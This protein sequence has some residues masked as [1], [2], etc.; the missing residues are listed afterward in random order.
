MEK[1]QEFLLEVFCCKV[2]K[3]QNEAI[4]GVTLGR[5]D[6][7]SAFDNKPKEK[8]AEKSK[9]QQIHLKDRVAKRTIVLISREKI[10]E[11][12][13]ERLSKEDQMVY[14]TPKFGMGV[15]SGGFENV[16]GPFYS[17]GFGSSPENLQKMHSKSADAIR[18]PVFPRPKENKK[19]PMVLTRSR[20]SLDHIHPAT[21]SRFLY[22]QHEKRERVLS[23]EPIKIKGRILEYDQKYSPKDVAKNPKLKR[24]KKTLKEFAKIEKGLVTAKYKETWKNR[25]N[26]LK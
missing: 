5:S 4:A 11:E 13:Q 17:G 1:I 16:E 6:F 14:D 9:D 10:E 20:R 22:L 3:G 23:E 7:P 15:H 26:P 25:P 8:T 18:T 21:S 2:E 12:K 19:K 24:A